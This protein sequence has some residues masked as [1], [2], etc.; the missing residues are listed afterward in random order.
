M[1]SVDVQTGRQRVPGWPA[2]WVQVQL[3]K[4]H[5]Y[6]VMPSEGEPFTVSARTNYECMLNITEEL[7]RRQR[8]AS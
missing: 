2:V 5:T 3:Q 4:R 6:R 1:G 7:R 8:A